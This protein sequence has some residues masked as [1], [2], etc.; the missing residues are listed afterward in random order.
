MLLLLEVW[1]YHMKENSQS[2]SSNTAVS[3]SKCEI[4]TQ[5]PQ[6]L[7]TEKQEIENS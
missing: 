6:D 2:C 7:R 3:Q 1:S 5:F 4:S